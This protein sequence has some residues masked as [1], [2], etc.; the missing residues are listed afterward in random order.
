MKNQFA[1]V[2]LASSLILIGC[3]KKTAPPPAPTANAPDENPL[4][5]PGNYV[6]AVVKAQ[7]SAVK[8]IGLAEINSA[9]SRF[10]VEEARYPKDLN[11][12]V[13]KKYLAVIPDLPR[14][15]KY[16]YDPNSG[17]AKVVK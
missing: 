8:T 5:A 6:G 17:Q 3:E 13:E 11:E 7:N 15:M 12:L 2:I 10:Y 16:V 14:G 9:V 4:H 1:F